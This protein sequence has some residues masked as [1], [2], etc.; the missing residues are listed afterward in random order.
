MTAAAF[1]TI[2]GA[3]LALLMDNGHARLAP[4]DVDRY[5]PRTADHLLDTAGH[6]FRMARSVRRGFGTRH[7]AELTDAQRDALG[8]YLDSVADVLRCM[9]AA[10]RGESGGREIAAAEA[11]LRSLGFTA[12][13][14]TTD[15]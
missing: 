10:E 12:P 8:D 3:T 7:T 11:G 4:P 2:P 15:A 9:T 5:P 6:A 13:K 1:Y 14:E